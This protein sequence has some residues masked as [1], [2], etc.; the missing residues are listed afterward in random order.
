MGKLEIIAT[1]NYT[2]FWCWSPQSTR[3]T[4]EMSLLQFL[5]KSLHRSHRLLS[6]E[7]R[8]RHR[9][10]TTASELNIIITCS[11]HFFICIMESAASMRSR[12]LSLCKNSNRYFRGT[13]YFRGLCGLTSNLENLG[14]IVY[15]R[16]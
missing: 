16:Y 3:P 4:Q 1:V 7:T 13:K 8:E 15:F 12:Y 10:S 2:H 14:I 11:E 6:L 9:Y 5:T